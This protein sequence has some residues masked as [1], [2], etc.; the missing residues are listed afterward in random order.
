[1]EHVSH[2][3]AFFLRTLTYDPFNP[4]NIFV[5]H[6]KSHYRIVNHNVTKL[7]GIYYYSFYFKLL[8]SRFLTNKLSGDIPIDNP[9]P[10]LIDGL[11]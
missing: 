11:N 5:T 8:V 4:W 7:A 3:Q 6:F 1:M 10:E 9:T 2:V